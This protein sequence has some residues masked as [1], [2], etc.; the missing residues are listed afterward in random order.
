MNWKQF[1][2]PD[3]RK[4]MVFVI[5]LIL[6]SLTFF[7]S[8]TAKISSLITDLSPWDLTCMSYT[9]LFFGSKLEPSVLGLLGNVIGSLL[10]IINIV[11][12]Y[13]VAF[14]NLLGTFVWILYW[15]LFSCL[16]IWIYDKFRKRK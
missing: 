15:Y 9:T 5:F 10:I 12:F 2:K 16:I 6:T 11:P 4:I 8:F 14:N 7:C 13:L 1:L 3:W